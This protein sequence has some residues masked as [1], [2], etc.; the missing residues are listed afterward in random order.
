MLAV[1]KDIY[2]ETIAT[3]AEMVSS[4]KVFIVHI[5]PFISRLSITA[6]ISTLGS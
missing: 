5:N 1:L 2:G 6:G 4:I 3:A